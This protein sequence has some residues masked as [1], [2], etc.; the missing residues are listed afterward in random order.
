MNRPAWQVAYIK[1]LH[2]QIK[3][4]DSWTDEE[5]EA[6]FRMAHVV[7]NNDMARGFEA[8]YHAGNRIGRQEER[9]YNPNIKR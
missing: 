1:W 2:D 7:M 4:E 3:P 8:G 5:L 9:Q 6:C